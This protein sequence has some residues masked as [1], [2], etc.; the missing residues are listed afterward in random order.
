MSSGPSSPP[1]A[2]LHDYVHPRPV[3]IG[4]MPAQARLTRAD[5]EQ[6]FGPGTEAEKLRPL[7]QKGHFIARQQIAIHVAGRILEGL[8]VCCPWVERSRIEIPASRARQLGI[9]VPVALLEGA[10]TASDGVECLLLGPTGTLQLRAGLSIPQR[11]LHLSPTDARAFHLADGERTRVVVPGVRGA[12]F[13]DVLVRV[14]EQAVLELHID[15]DEAN[16]L[17]AC[18]GD[19]SY[20]INEQ[21]LGLDLNLRLARP[22]AGG[23]LM[24]ERDLRDTLR[25]Q[26]RVR[27]PKGVL[28]TP[29]AC[30]L[31]RRL[32]LD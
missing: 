22:A 30:D 10:E 13:N 4:I 26:G 12:I 25:K 24:T 1:L 11:H 19:L 23:R 32:K 21:R 3:P 27:I 28:L 7:P 29:S 14:S 9:R 15:E 17:L 18:N 8:P 16:A 6:L 2:A 5:F 20:V 31:A